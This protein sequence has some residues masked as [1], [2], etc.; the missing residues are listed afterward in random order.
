[1]TNCVKCGKKLRPIG[2]SRS[3]GNIKYNDWETRKYHKACWKEEKNFY[4]IYN[5]CQQIE[6]H[7][8]SDILLGREKK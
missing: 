8:L 4:Y 1:M 5:K 7:T 2:T 3:N 6:S